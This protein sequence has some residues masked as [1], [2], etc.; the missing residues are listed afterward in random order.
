MGSLFAGGPSLREIDEYFREAF[1]RHL[2]K[3]EAIG[4]GVFRENYE[5][6]LEDL[7]GYVDRHNLSL[8]K[9]TRFAGNMEGLLRQYLPK[10]AVKV[11]VKQARIAMCRQ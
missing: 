10:E 8:W 7:R 6:L 4:D 9:R 2:G 1:E 3:A 11:L 5:L